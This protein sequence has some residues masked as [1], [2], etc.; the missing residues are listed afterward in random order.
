MVWKS[1]VNLPMISKLQSTLKTTDYLSFIFV[2]RKFTSPSS[3]QKKKK[4]TLQ[5]YS[6]EN[7][8]MDIGVLKG[9][10]YCTYISEGI[11]IVKI[12]L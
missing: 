7:V 4:R 12:F 9:T 8:R 2:Y 11:Y 1:F 10:H 5:N 6:K 3:K